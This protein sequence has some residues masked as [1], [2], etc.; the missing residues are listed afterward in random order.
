MKTNKIKVVLSLN[1]KRIAEFNDYYDD[2]DN[3]GQNR[4][5]SGGAKCAGAHTVKVTWIEGISKVAYCHTGMADCG[6]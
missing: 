5:A 3:D 6:G 1:K 2:T 4:R